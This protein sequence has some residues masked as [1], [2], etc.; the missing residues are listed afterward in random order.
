MAKTTKTKKTTLTVEV[1]YNPQKTDPE[2]LACA[3]DRLLETALSIPEVMD[4]YGNPTIGEFFVAKEA[5]STA[6]PKIILN[7]SGGLVQEVFGSDPAITV[8]LVDWDTEGSDPSDNG[9]VEIPDERG[10]TQ[11]AHVAECGVEPLEQLAGTETEAALKA[12]GLALTLPADSDRTVARKIRLPCYGITLMLARENDAEEPGSGSIVSDLRDPD[13]AANQQ[14]NA[15][16]DGLESLIL[17]HACAGVDVESSAYVEGIET[18][19]D[20]IANE[21]GST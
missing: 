14:Y 21:Y 2:G 1:E 11:L 19:V 3:M 16:I 17:A 12:A 10:G 5:S 20:A 9:M 4:E 13:T 6:A 18:A 15:A 7:M 8:A